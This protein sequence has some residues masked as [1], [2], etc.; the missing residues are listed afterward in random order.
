MAQAV[1]GTE[2]DQEGG[3]VLAE[4]VEVAE[5]HSFNGVVVAEAPSVHG[6]FRD[7]A[8]EDVDKD[9]MESVCRDGRHEVDAEEA[10]LVCVVA[11]EAEYLVVT[12]RDAT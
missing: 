3:D 12:R 1:P 6:Q 2:A 11:A 5:L 7:L 9:C 10:V 8:A 4:I